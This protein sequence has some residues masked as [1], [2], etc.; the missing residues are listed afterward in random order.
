VKGLLQQFLSEADDLLDQVD[1]G[2]LELERDPADGAR[3]NDVFRAAH[4]LKGSS[5]LFDLPHLTR[6]THAAE[7]LLDAIRAGRLQLTADLADDLLTAFDLVRS[8]LA[9]VDRTDR[10]PADAATVGAA[11]AARLRAPLGDGPRPAAAP[12]SRVEQGPAVTGAAPPDPSQ[13]PP[14]WLLDGLGTDGVERVR[15]WLER[16]DT[17]CRAVR[18]EPGEQCFFI[19]EDPLYLVSQTPA[20]EALGIGPREPWPALDAF[21]EYRCLL[22]FTVVTRATDAELQYLYRYVSEEIEVVEVAADGLRTLLEGAAASDGPAADGGVA[23]RAIPDGQLAAA[24]EV[25][26]AQLRAM[27]VELPAEQAPARISSAGS[28]AGAA[29]AA[30]GRSQE[31][32]DELSAVLAE[33]LRDGTPQALAALLELELERGLETA[34]RP[35]SVPGAPEVDGDRQRA[36]VAVDD[37]SP[38][39]RR[40]GAVDRRAAGTPRVLKVDQATVD[41]LLDLVGQLVVAKNGLPFLAASAED[42]WHARALARQIKDQYGVVNRISEELQAAVMDVRMLPMSVVFARFPRMVRD[43]ARTLGKQV[44]LELDGQ[45][46]A[47]DKDVIEMLGD[48]LVHVIRNSLDHGVEPPDERL[49]AGKPAQATVRLRAVQEPDAV[50]IEVSDDGRGIDP[51]MIKRKAYERGLITEEQLG[52]LSDEDAVNLVFLPGFSTVDQVSDVSGRGVGM[53]AVRAGV[54]A[55]GGSVRLASAPGRGSEVRLRLPLSMAVSRVMIVTIGGQRFGV[56][57]D[58]VIETVRV[59]RESV[60]RVEHQEVIVLRD[61]VVPLVDL[62]GTLRVGGGAADQ[63]LVSILVTR[64]G[65]EDIGLVVEEFHPAAEVIVKPMEGILAGSRE[66]CGTALMGD[67]SVLLVLD[68]K[69]VLAGAG[70]AE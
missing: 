47:A 29:L 12:S 37:E 55:M 25:L 49:A 7:D 24:R 4:T 32:L 16:A 52:T 41:R 45:D 63:E 61:A 27:R 67:G 64:P 39:D 10:L 11:L 59:P 58:L 5:G 53:D 26:A 57:V 13:T 38:A 15:D 2:L 17:R 3:L 42:R 8:W 44:Q 1:S 68:V 65:D 21:D 50:V 60:S 66:F 23:D 46:T 51:E 36:A 62:A 6:L 69:E 70:D 28:A 48:P 9:V 54:E 14:A 18:F 56:P 33:A 43:L 31:R 40:V 35:P 22:V 30:M 34:P 19:G 20:I